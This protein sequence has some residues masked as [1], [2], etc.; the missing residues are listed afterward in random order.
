M[1]IDL[2]IDNPMIYNSAWAV[3]IEYYTTYILYK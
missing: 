1:K 2:Y 3:Y